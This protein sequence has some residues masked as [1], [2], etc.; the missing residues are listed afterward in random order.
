MIIFDT[1]TTGLPEKSGV[2]LNLQPHII[3]FA[4]LKVTT[5]SLEEIDRISFLCRA[6]VPVP[7]QITEITGI[8]DA[9]LNGKKKFVSHYLDLVNFFVGETMLVAHNLPFDRTMLT[10]E[11]M[12]LDKVTQ[13]PWPWRHVCTAE[14]TAHMN[15]GKYFKQ[16]DLYAHLFGEPA[17]QTH[18]AMDDV[19]Q[20]Y[21]IILQLRKDGVFL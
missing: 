15:G 13:F 10:F 20:L 3:E 19:M 21:K 6:P 12:R 16:E 5:H 8:T 7:A 11:L 2:R 4:A 9:D 18:R 14:E 17:N 1:E